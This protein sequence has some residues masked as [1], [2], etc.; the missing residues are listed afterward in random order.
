MTDSWANPD[1]Q[2]RVP[3]NVCA[4]CRKP[5]LSGHR[6]QA[7]YI[8]V[9]PDARNPNRITEKG[10]QLGIDNEFTHVKCD[11]PYLRGKLVSV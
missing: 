2:K 6:I 10:L 4:S 8:V 3:D 7:A 9:D 11:D 5:I 1:I